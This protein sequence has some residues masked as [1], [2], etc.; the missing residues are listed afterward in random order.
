[1]PSFPAVSCPDG[2][3]GS[4][5]GS[6]YKCTD[7]S[8]R[9]L[10]WEDAEAACKQDGGTLAEITTKEENA[11]LAKFMKPIVGKKGICK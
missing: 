4:F 5:K 9:G 6:C 8:V 2:Y 7:V 10:S 1:M 3:T 11:Y